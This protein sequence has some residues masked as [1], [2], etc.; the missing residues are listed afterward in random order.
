M[1]LNLNHLESLLIESC[2]AGTFITNLS[3]KLIECNPAFVKMFGYGSKQEIL[4]ANAVSFYSS[5][6]ER[7]NYLKNLHN[8]GKVRGYKVKA[9]KKDGQKVIHSINSDF[10]KD[11]SGE[12]YILGSTIDITE[13]EKFGDKLNESNKKYQD[14]IENSLEIIQSFDAEGKLIF[15]NRI[16]HEKLEYTEEDIK[17]LNL[18]DIIAEEHKNHCEKLFQDVLNGK[19]LKNVEVEFVSKSGKK[20][21]LEGNIVPLE[22][23]GK[24]IA[25]HAFFRDITEKNRA[26]RKII[27]QE[28]LLQTVFDTVPICLYLKSDK[29]Q[30]IHVNEVMEKT[31]GTKVKD[32]YDSEIFPENTCSL[33]S[34]SD[35]EALENPGKIIRF[36]LETDFSGVKKHFYAGKQVLFD[37]SKKSFNIFGFSLDISELKNSLKKVEES[38]KVLQFIINNA[39]GGFLLF[40]FEANSDSFKLEYANDFS[41]DL[42]EIDHVQS[43][44]KDIFHF[45]NLEM[46]EL[47]HDKR[48]VFDFEKKNPGDEISKNYS[49]RVSTIVGWNNSRTL[50]VYIIDVTEQQKLISELEIQLNE[51]LVLIGEIHHRVKNNLAVIDGLLELK[52]AQS[53]D[54]SLNSNISDIQMRI[55]SIALVHQKL[56][57][58]SIFNAIN[59]KEYIP[60][61][62]NFYKKLFHKDEIKEISFDIQCEKDFFI[63]ISK[64]VTFGLILS[65]LISNSCKYGLDENN[66]SVSIKVNQEKDKL[67]VQYADKGK[68]LPK[69]ISQ[70]KQGGFGFR[71]MDNLIRQLKGKYEIING[72]GFELNFEFIL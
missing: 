37:E 38:E 11:E 16:W 56:Y 35:Q 13:I 70:L 51:N 19:S 3:G 71:L 29:G 47:T 24:L 7:E 69:G 45:L 20:F 36:E 1:N 18:F 44:F 60:E 42:L 12:T 23:N 72:K 30:Y 2:H 59:L 14:L 57:Q 25:S 67:K 31:L 66:L 5:K 55:K 64:A 40:N 41:K 63:L 9:S 21:L 61:L 27:E 26:I 15:C 58:S 6:E 43:N 17:N 52:K 65:E 68:G 46:D 54:K 50:I 62:A 22:Q 49:I 48:W 53:K 28:K 10:F 4:Q 34:T 8:E 32:K 39:Q 33:L